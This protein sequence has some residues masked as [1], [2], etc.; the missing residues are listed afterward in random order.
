VFDAGTVYAWLASRK[1]H[2][3]ITKLSG[4]DKYKKYCIDM[5]V[6]EAMIFAELHGLIYD[7][8]IVPIEGNGAP[9]SPHKVFV[10]EKILHLSKKESRFL[11][12]RIGWLYRITSHASCKAKE[13]FAKRSVDM[14]E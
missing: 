6:I 10:N 4:D 12:E 3:Q 13:L 14:A 11:F 9:R 5:L 7:A 2:P 1:H 8:E